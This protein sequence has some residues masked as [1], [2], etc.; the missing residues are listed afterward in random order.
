MFIMVTMKATAMTTEYS[1][2]DDD[3]DEYDEDDDEDKVDDGEPGRQ[4]VQQRLR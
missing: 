2:D 1:N 4:A 3:K